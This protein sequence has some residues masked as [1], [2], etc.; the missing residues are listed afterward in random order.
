MASERFVFEFKSSGVRAVKRNLDKTAKAAGNAAKKTDLLRTSLLG[1]GAFTIARFAAGLADSYLNLNNRIKVVTSSTEEFNAAQAEVFRIAN[2]TRTSV[3]QVAD[4]YSRVSLSIKE[5][6]ESNKVALEITESLNQAVIIGGS[7]SVEA[8]KGIV[9]LAQGLSSGT[10]RGDELRSVLEQL[11]VVADVISKQ[12][13][14]TRSALRAMGAAGEI[15]ADQIT[16]A[17]KNSREELAERFAK[18]PPTIGQAFTVLRN[19]LVQL[20]GSINEATGIITIFARG[21]IL[22]AENLAT[23]AKLALIA[24]VNILFFKNQALIAAA[25]TRVVTIAT[26]A[27]QI[28]LFLLSQAY[29]N[30]RTSLT[31][32][33]AGLGGLAIAPAVILSAVAAVVL[34]RDQIVLSEKNMVTLGTVT[35][36]TGQAISD[37]FRSFFGKTKDGF[38]EVKKEGDGFFFGLL[39]TVAKVLDFLS[40]SM[41]AFIL[42]NKISFERL[43]DNLA[44]AFQGIVNTII[45]GVNLIAGGL[46]RITGVDLSIDPADFADGAKARLAGISFGQQLKDGIAASFSRSDA[47]DRAEKSI[48]LL[49]NKAAATSAASLNAARDANGRETS[50]DRIISSRIKKLKEEVSAMRSSEQ[51]QK[52]LRVVRELE[53][54]ARQK[55]DIKQKATIFNLIREKAAL[56]ELKSVKDNFTSAVTDLTQENTLLRLNTEERM[57][58]AQILSITEGT[59]VALNTSQVEQLRLLMEQNTALERGNELNQ[60]AQDFRDSLIPK[61]DEIIAKQG[62]LNKAYQEGAINVNTFG[63]ESA[64]LEAQFASGASF[65]DGL[66]RGISAVKAQILDVGSTVESALVG[67]FNRAS[68]ALAEFAV[69]GQADFKALT[70]SILKDLARILIQQALAGLIGAASGGGARPPGVEGPLL[71]SGDFFGRQAGGPVQAGRAVIVGEERPELFVPTQSGNIQPSVPQASAPNITVV[72][73][74]DPKE[75]QSNIAAGDSDEALVNFVQ[76]NSRTI[77]KMLR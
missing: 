77:K 32:F 15:S 23:I 13:G 57:L 25:A 10:L 27:Y 24:G 50:G 56:E 63:V 3:G 6:G 35:S 41:T 58:Q 26:T 42:V 2:A 72:N 52:G 38:A 68:D 44:V 74:S 33:L 64:K 30:V 43:F 34:F 4:T 20:F 17:F 37:S 29:V 16:A 28:A 53:S 5:L 71:P 12:L 21:M 18:L 62:A 22:L 73:V 45:D 9:Q 51:V 59:T 19:N 31:G 60:V 7:S 61:A 1:F 55:L 54:T 36:A 47:G 70:E 8:E 39:R 46:D 49:T 48:L 76:R 65:A 11:P 66:T 40:N 75:I 69:T 14:V 67:A